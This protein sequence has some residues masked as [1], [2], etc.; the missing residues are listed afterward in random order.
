[1]RRAVSVLAGVRCSAP[2]GVATG[3]APPRGR[4][5]S[6]CGLHPMTWVAGERVQPEADGR[7]GVAAAGGLGVYV[8]G[9]RMW[10]AS[11][12]AWRAAW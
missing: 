6:P 10:E 1:M 12:T 9:L 2:A 3:A 11:I 4:R 8:N 5:F 7:F